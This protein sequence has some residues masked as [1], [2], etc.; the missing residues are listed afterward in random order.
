[1]DRN[2]D[3]LFTG[4]YDKTIKL[5]QIKTGQCLSTIRAHS[6][7][8]SSLQYDPKF[9]MLAS[10][11]WDCTIK[12]WNMKTQQNMLTLTSTNGNYVYCVRTNLGDNELIAGTELK[13]VDIWDI[14]KKEKITTFYG[15]LERINSLKYVNNLILS[16]S[17]DKHGR[18]W[19]KRT[20]NCEILLS[21]HTR[22]ITQ[23]DYDQI[24]NRVFT[25]SMD[26]TIKIWDIRKNKEIRTLV[27]HSNSVYSIAFDQSRLI[28]GSKDNSIRIWNFMN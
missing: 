7:W 14:D 1:M 19:D 3:I 24:N 6:S 21:G 17:E 16:G 13:T 15:H 18:I 27:G 22:G 4:S 2:E 8:V 20:G 23:V 9:D 12:L 26:K 10:S 5:W 25:S 28:S 11:S